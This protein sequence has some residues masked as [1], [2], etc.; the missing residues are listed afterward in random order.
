[1]RRKI[2]KLAREFG[3][4]TGRR[5]NMRMTTDYSSEK[6]KLQDDGT[7]FLCTEEKT[8]I[9]NSM[10]SKKPIKNEGPKKGHLWGKKK[11]QKQNKC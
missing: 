5:T 7:T 4:I 9:L 8:V 6:I 10:F 11:K 1:M 3:D 2:I